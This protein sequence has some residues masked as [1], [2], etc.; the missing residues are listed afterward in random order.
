ML[1]SEGCSALLNALSMEGMKDRH[2]DAVQ[3][4]S[5]VVPASP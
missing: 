3:E 5:Q 2:W 4:G 1:C